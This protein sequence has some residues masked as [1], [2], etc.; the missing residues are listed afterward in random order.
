MQLSE[1]QNEIVHISSG[2]HLV[3][4]PPGSGKTE[5][6]SQRITRALHA[7]HIHPSEML[8]LTFTNRAARNMHE[9]IKEPVFIGTFHTFGSDVL[10]KEKCIP[11][12][13][14]LL[15]EEDAKQLME[16]AKLNVVQHLQLNKAI[17]NEIR[18]SV[19]LMYNAYLQQTEKDL[20]TTPL[21]KE[22]AQLDVHYITEI[23]KEYTKLKQASLSID[24]DDILTLTIEYF[25][26]NVSPYKW[27]Q[28]DE[29]QDLNALQWY[30]IDLL[31]QNQSHIMLFGDYEQCIYSFIGARKDILHAHSSEATK[32][33]LTV[34][35]RS[36]SYL[37][38]IYSHFSSH[39]FS[40][41]WAKPPESYIQEKNK[42]NALL[43][44]IK[45]GSAYQEAQFISQNMVRHLLNEGT[46][47]ILTR[48]NRTADTYSNFLNTEK[49]EHFKVS[50]FDLFH[51]TCIK[52]L[53]AILNVYCFPNK[54]MYWARIYHLFGKVNSLSSG[55][56][57][58]NDLYRCGL[59]P[60]NLL[61][62]KASLLEEFQ[63]IS[64]ERVVLFDTET[65]GLDTS[66]A[67][68]IQIAAIEVING[69]I[70]QEFEVYLNTTHS[71]EETKHVHHIDEQ[72]LKEKGVHATEGLSAFL[73]FVGNSPL[74]AHNMRYDWNVLSA[75]LKRALLPLPDLKRFDTLLLSR[76]CFPTERSYTLA[77][78]LESL[79]LEGVNSHN[80]LDDV[81][82][83]VQLFLEIRK[84]LV[85]LLEKQTW[86]Y[87]EYKTVIDKL[88]ENIVP[89][90]TAISEFKEPDI[91]SAIHLI[92]TDLQERLH[93]SF[94]E[95]DKP[96]LEKLI[97]HMIHT[98][99]GDTLKNKLSFLL[100]KYDQY[101]EADLL[102]GDEQ[103]VVATIHKAKG[104]EFD[105]VIIPECVEG[106]YPFS[107]AKD[108][109][110]LEE[111]A[112]LF[113]VALT[114]AKKSIVLSSHTHKSS[115]KSE[116][117]PVKRSPFIEP[118][119]HFFRML[120]R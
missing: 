107:M 71:L 90:L 81:R 24:F 111:E 75:N 118:I 11:K 83:T 67:D 36:P 72:V 43:Y 89:L 20:P 60:K 97:R 109:N 96:Y 52:D 28:I 7:E 87:T 53:L 91:R 98:E 102:L 34:N 61:S 117:F 1:K 17:A 44:L 58:V 29:V 26:T 59:Q 78:L 114:R 73:E 64:S 106:I 9:R 48:T 103:V 108:E 99:E 45:N 18:P 32:H 10:F 116:P 104:L 49:I 57:M 3:L 56:Q 112:R 70:G 16:E 100:P 30:L 31:N 66:V 82:A 115:Y 19:L 38:D 85:P 94:K 14:S 63:H 113:Y 4:A 35:Y 65:T 120:V 110:E 76:C 92:F 80:A 42:K 50:G 21:P 105:T 40:S 5:L 88:R 8:C 69:V 55:R 74:I 33:F 51:R 41:E 15:D 79:K 23:C 25:Q 12:Q 2:F 22:I 62:D 95:E 84:S 101:K 6:L 68:I 54:R 39:F 27:I 13:T 93:Y 46:V 86:F 47:A 119:H 77:D 37:L